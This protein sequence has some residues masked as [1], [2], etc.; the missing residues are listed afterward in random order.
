LRLERKWVVA[1]PGSLPLSTSSANRVEELGGRHDGHL[2]HAATDGQDSEREH[3][4]H[5]AVTKDGQHLSAEEQ[6]VLRLVTEHG[7]KAETLGAR[8]VHRFSASR[9]EVSTPVLCRAV[10]RYRA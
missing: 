10:C 3:D 6:T 1:A 7:R 5:D 4:H 9:H 8:S 2:T